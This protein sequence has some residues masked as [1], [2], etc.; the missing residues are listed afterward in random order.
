M[1]DALHICT[2]RQLRTKCNVNLRNSKRQ[3]AKSMYAQPL[4]IPRTLLHLSR[5]K[6]RAVRTARE[7]QQ[8]KIAGRGHKHTRTNGEGRAQSSRT[9]KSRF[10][11]QRE[12]PIRGVGALQGTQKKQETTEETTDLAP[13]HAHRQTEKATPKRNNV[14]RTH[15]TSCSRKSP[16][17]IRPRS[18]SPRDNGHRIRN[19][20]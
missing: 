17:A 20:Q 4:R 10:R 15:L 1:T 18:R 14:W 3:T 19:K 2:H 13:L 5:R 16:V 9:V 8:K 6:G 7:P 11:R 12:A